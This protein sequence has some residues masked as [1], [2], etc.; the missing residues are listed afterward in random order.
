MIQQAAHKRI[1]RD[2]SLSKRQ[3]LSWYASLLTI[4]LHWQTLEHGCKRSRVNMGRTCQKL[5]Y[6]VPRVTLTRQKRVA[7]S[8]QEQTS[9]R[10]AKSTVWQASMRRVPSN[11][12]LSVCTAQCRAQ[13]NLLS[14]AKQ[15]EW[16]YVKVL[17]RLIPT[18]KQDERSI[19]RYLANWNQFSTI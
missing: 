14:R 8:S 16:T 12:N 13:P 4:K 15:N 9:I 1:S 10:H 18:T 3:T 2:K 19:D 11:G 7:H 5:A 6:A 17:T